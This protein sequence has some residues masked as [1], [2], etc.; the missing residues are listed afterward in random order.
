MITP[1][2]KL[3]CIGHLTRGIVAAA[4]ALAFVPTAAA[5]VPADQVELVERVMNRLLAVVEQPEQYDAWPPKWRVI[6]DDDVNAFVTLDAQQQD[7]TV[8]ILRVHRGLIEEI[9]EMNEDRLAF[10]LGHE[11][12]H[13]TRGHVTNDEGETD[14]LVAAYTREQ[15]LEADEQGMKYAVAAGY[16]YRE[17]MGA[18]QQFHE[19]GYDYT[20]FEGIGADHPSWVERLEL[21]ESDE[22]QK[23]YWRSMSAFQ[24]GV[25]FLQTQ[26]YL[27]AEFSFR[28][29]TKEFPKCYEAWVNMGYAQL[30]QYCDS[31]EE[32]DLRELGIGQLIVGGFY[33]RTE[34][35]GGS[36]PFDDRLW[37]EA[38]GSLQKALTLKSDL[39][40]AKANLAL[41][42]L[43]H[44]SGQPDVGQAAR[45]YAEVAELLEDEQAT[46][47]IDPLSRAALLAN[48]W[49]G[50]YHTD[51]SRN[52]AVLAEID[53]YLKSA[54][55]ARQTAS[56][57]TSVR[58]AIGYTQA[59]ALA[60]TSDAT[61]H[62]EAM[63][64]FEGYLKSTPKTSSWWNIAY[65]EYVA[66][67]G[68]L[69]V[70]PK[71]TEELQQPRTDDWRTV[72]GIE[73]PDGPSIMLSAALEPVASVLD[74]S[75]EG[76]PLFKRFN[77]RRYD[78][79][80]QGVSLIGKDKIIA[81]ILSGPN[82]PPV[83][84]RREALGAQPQQ[85]TIGMPRAEVEAL[86]GDAWTS[87]NT[88]I[89][90][91]EQRHEFYEDVGVAVRY[92]ADKTVVEIILTV[93]PH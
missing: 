48:A 55:K 29:V 51:E 42:Y 79:S 57:A 4:A 1:P 36:R 78:F 76:E 75:I 38:V 84:L 45:L 70:T 86:L 41:A 85:L 92:G 73:L 18:P 80:N 12:A 14:V 3:S 59:A 74:G 32:A 28:A 58:A 15:E 25:F 23:E 40:L 7:K 5:K 6:D 81:I 62:R 88:S 22:Q 50:L 64:L 43:V 71:A 63:T 17:A 49:V 91:P 13:L 30:M 69:N 33:S 77:L 53:A 82:A 54:E 56:A 27:A 26:N 65:D 68:K 93:A 21:L 90:D 16:S 61:S 87:T 19:A 8:P 46:A 89:I 35:L 31:L 20:S 47:N 39:L 37:W 9:A 34:T 44:P 83:E 72:G 60:A 67:A 66:L 24:T 11:L 52:A 10:V 2:H